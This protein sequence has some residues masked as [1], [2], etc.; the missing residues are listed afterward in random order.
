MLTALMADT[1]ALPGYYRAD[2]AARPQRYLMKSA[3]HVTALTSTGR[4][5][6][7]EK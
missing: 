5:G 7:P 4:H 2:V 1:T 3:G 6:G